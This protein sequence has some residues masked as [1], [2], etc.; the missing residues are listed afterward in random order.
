MKKPFFLTFLF[1]FII[2]IETSANENFFLEAKKNYENK[3]METSKFLLQ[4]N[5]VFNPKDAESYLYLA[6]I[7]NYEK[8]ESEEIKNLE[9]A[10]LLAPGNE[11]AIYMLIDIELEKSNYSEVKK[12]TT[13]FEQVCSKL[14]GKKEDIKE[15]LKNI[16]ANK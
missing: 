16:E 15:R 2:N 5:I 13:K 7:F 1:F 11:E 12:L 10:L 8:N 3:E 6:K 14:C 9:T 4:R